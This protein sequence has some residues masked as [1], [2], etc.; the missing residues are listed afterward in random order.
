MKKILVFLSFVYGFVY[1]GELVIIDKP[2]DFSEKR[3][4]LTK[5]YIKSRYFMD[6]DSIEIIPKVI[7]LHWTAEGDFEKSFARFKPELLLSDR[8]DI[9]GVSSL[10]VAAHFLVDKDGTIYRLM[11]ENW[12]GRH[13]IGLN[14]NSIGIENVGGVGDKEGDLTEA[15]VKA[16]IQLVKYLKEKYETIEYLI[17]HHE[18][19]NMKQTSLWL[20]RDPNYFTHKN[21][22]GDLFMKLVREGVDDL[23][24][25]KP[26]KGE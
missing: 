21:D 18:Y 24:L 8:K 20:E 19:G 13:T 7:V 12:M 15:Q 2:I 14:F 16:N 11:P 3:V 22:P 1:G 26:P 25:S 6:V 10:N 9:A 5:E 17:G 23:N 4:E